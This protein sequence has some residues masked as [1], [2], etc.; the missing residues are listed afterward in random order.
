[1]D[2]KKR[3][4]LSMI[5][6]ALCLI[7]ASADDYYYKI[8][9]YNENNELEDWSEYIKVTS[10]EKNDKPERYYVYHNGLGDLI[11][12]KPVTDG[13]KKYTLP[14]KDPDKIWGIQFANG[15]E[16][17]KNGQFSIMEG[18]EYFKAWVKIREHIKYLGLR[19]YIRD[20][21]NDNSYFQYMYNVEELELPK[22]GMTVGNGD[23]NGLMY[24]ANAYKLNR[25]TIQSNGKTVDITETNKTLL[26]RVGK[27]MFANCFGLSSKY[28]NRLI[29]DV[30][31]IKDNAFFADDDK[32]GNFSD[33]VDNKM[34]IEIPSSVKKIGYQAF[35]NR[36]TVT[37]LNIQGNDDLVIGS[38]AFKACD[39]LA[40]ISL[41]Q[42]NT[43]LQ[44][45]WRN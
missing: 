36:V 12:G 24:F 25:I 26:N 15:Q 16:I 22:N 14:Q 44:T 6:L 7:Q 33:A 29:K 34:P 9:L 19:D 23:D 42:D 2:M 20:T 28:I 18:D 10:E 1:M 17:D 41:T 21:Y 11:A 8:R 45:R 38:E 32:R 30:E 5:L 43:K 35:Y 31:E 40:K 4:L 39:K 27:F 3:I 13:K 37:G